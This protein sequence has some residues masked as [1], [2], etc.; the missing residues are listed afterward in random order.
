MP[1]LATPLV[2]ETRRKSGFALGKLAPTRTTCTRPLT[3]ILAAPVTASV[4]VGWWWV[5][6]AVVPVDVVGRCGLRLVLPV[7]GA[8]LA[9]G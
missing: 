8:P 7:V 5:T 6:A 3:A 9:A 1:I 4:R 2:T